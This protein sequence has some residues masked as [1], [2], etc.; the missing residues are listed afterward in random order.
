MLNLSSAE[1]G[2]VFGWVTILGA[3]GGTSGQI[4]RSFLGLNK[5][6]AAMKL[7][8]KCKSGDWPWPDVQI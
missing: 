2:L 7:L 6:V 4:G 1:L 3:R 8:H 5:L